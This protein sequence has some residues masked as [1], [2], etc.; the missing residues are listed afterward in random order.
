[1]WLWQLVDKRHSTEGD[2]GK[3]LARNL[4]PNQAPGT[5]EHSQHVALRVGGN[6]SGQHVEA[7]GAMEQVAAAS[8]PTTT[9]ARK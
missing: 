2:K 4:A 5:S 6:V 8:Q 3:G 7:W 1:M 9:V